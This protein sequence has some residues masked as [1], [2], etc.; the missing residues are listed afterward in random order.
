MSRSVDLDLQYKATWVDY[1]NGSRG[2]PGFF[3][4]DTV[5]HGPVI[6]FVFKF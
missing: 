3:Q 5:T 2:S 6:G 4:Y 1:K